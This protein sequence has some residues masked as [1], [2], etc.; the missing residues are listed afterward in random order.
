M[1]NSLAVYDNISI[2]IKQISN[3]D[4]LTEEEEK[5]LAKKWF[6]EKDLTAAQKLIVANLRFVVKIAYQYKNYKMKM[7]DLIQEGNIGLMEAVK[8][9]D[10]NQGVRLIHYASWWIK[11]KIQSY[12]LKMWRLVKIGTTQAQRKLFFKLNQ[13]YEKIMQQH[14]GNSEAVVE[15]AK[16]LKLKDSQ[17]SEMMIRMNNKEYSLNNSVN[18]DSSATF[19]D[20]IPVNKNVEED[21]IEKESLKLNKK[22]LKEGFNLLN[23]REKDIIKIRFFSK[24][25]SLTYQ[26][27]GD[28]YGISK[29]RVQQIEKSALNKIKYLFEEKEF[30]IA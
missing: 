30:L 13:T 28:K 17:V 11:S 3:Y 16:E 1:L 4:L 8:K 15:V 9:F 19:E 7:E 20:I 5:S 12:I 29:Q 24:N 10:P 2:Y 25:K 26:E 22:I 6:Y 27:I 18:D 21:F 14:I 23:D